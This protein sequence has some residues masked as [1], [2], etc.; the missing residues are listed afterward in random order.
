[1]YPEQICSLVG[2]LIK[3]GAGIHTRSLKEQLH[4]FCYLARSSTT[5]TETLPCSESVHA[6]DIDRN[7]RLAIWLLL[8]NGTFR[9]QQWVKISVLS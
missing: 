1:M 3:R 8:D 4:A 2:K 6:A 9:E 7:A 5:V